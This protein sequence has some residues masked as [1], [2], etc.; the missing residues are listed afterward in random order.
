MENWTINEKIYITQKP[1]EI[2]LYYCKFVGVD[3]HSGKIV[4]QSVPLLKK[5]LLIIF[6]CGSQELKCAMAVE[7]NISLLLSVCA[8]RIWKIYK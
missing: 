6:C 4:N 2:L 3:K 5:S 1:M 8:Q 7:E